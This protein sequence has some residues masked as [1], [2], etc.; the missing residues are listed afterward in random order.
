MSAHRWCLN[1]HRALESMYTRMHRIEST[2]RRHTKH[3]ARDRDTGPAV[4]LV[5][6]ERMQCDRQSGNAVCRSEMTVEIGWIFLFLLFSLSFLF[7]CNG[8]RVSIQSR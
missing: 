2:R 8:T 6:W 3:S 1:P 5:H 4:R 7:V